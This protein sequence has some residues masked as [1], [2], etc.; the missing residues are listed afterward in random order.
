M[1]NF[2]AQVKCSKTSNWEFWDDVTFYK[3][4]QE[5]QKQLQ[6]FLKFMGDAS[7]EKEEEIKSENYRVVEVNMV[8]KSICSIEIGL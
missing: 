6:T 4:A 2:A 5:A 1:S 7:T 3:T 8:V